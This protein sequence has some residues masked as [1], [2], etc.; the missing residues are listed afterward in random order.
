MEGLGF[1]CFADLIAKESFD[2]DFISQLLGDEGDVI[3]H[4]GVALI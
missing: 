1:L 3:L 2:D 4:R